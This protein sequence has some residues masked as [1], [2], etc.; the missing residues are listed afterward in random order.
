VCVNASILMASDISKVWQIVIVLLTTND[1]M[2]LRK[3]INVWVLTVF[4]SI[5]SCRHLVKVR[6]LLNSL[7]WSRALCATMNRMKEY[8]LW[9]FTIPASVN[10]LLQPSF[11]CNAM[12]LE[13]W[14]EWRKR[15]TYRFKNGMKQ[16]S[17]LPKLVTL[18][19]SMHL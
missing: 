5:G 11:E 4:F 9:E 15:N 12:D 1:I 7:R 6:I 3:K 17:K 16:T 13:G 18:R 14:G 2:I 10:L 8:R 19:N